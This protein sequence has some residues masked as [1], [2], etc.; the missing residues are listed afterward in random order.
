[1]NYGLYLSATGVLANSHRQDVIANNIANAETHGFKR[2]VTTF[3]QRLTEAQM[4]AG[5]H[6]RTNPLLENIGGG[7]LVSPTGVDHTQ[8]ELETTSNNL[9]AAIMGNGYFAV[10]D[11]KETRLTRNGAFSIDRTGYLVMADNPNLKVLDRDQKPIQLDG[12]Y[13]STISLGAFG[14]ITQNGQAAGQ[15]GMF[16][17]ADP[18]KLAKRGGNLLANT[19]DTAAG[20][21]LLRAKA[22]LRSEFLE[23][24]NVDPAIELTQLMDAQRQLE[25]NANMIRYQDATLGRLVNDVGKI[26]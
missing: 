14:E 12:R 6:G 15:I 13:R 3:Q 18:S 1:V 25:A 17:V 19:D 16:D 8:G 7:F 23:R 2:D 9:D 4:M 21:Q 26:S 10:Q 22:T 5:G 11:G 24:S 20:K